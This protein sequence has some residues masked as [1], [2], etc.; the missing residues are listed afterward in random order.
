MS[1]LIA[2]S[3]C[4]WAP[5]Y[6][7]RS[8]NHSYLSYWACVKRVLTSRI[9]SAS[10]DSHI[11]MEKTTY[12]MMLSVQDC[13]DCEQWMWVTVFK[14]LWPVFTMSIY[15]TNTKQIKHYTSGDGLPWVFK[16]Y[17]LISA[18]IADSH[19]ISAEFPY[20]LISALVPTPYQL[21]ST[22]IRDS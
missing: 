17:H 7:L 14:G 18:P 5:G 22:S 19:L 15:E 1:H 20:N 12:Q 3:W 8:R 21:I 10:G 4:C 9:A 13:L 6:V 2:L 11:I 16:P